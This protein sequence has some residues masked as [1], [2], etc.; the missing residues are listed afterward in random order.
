MT[1]QAAQRLQQMLG[2]KQ[3]QSGAIK[4]IKS[5]RN[6]GNI[7]NGNAYKNNGMNSFIQPNQAGSHSLVI[8]Q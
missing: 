1:G 3:G 7:N 4:S 2:F 5:E 6:V 8:E